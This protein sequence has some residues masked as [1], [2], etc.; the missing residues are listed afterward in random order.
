VTRK[1]EDETFSAYVFAGRLY[2]ELQPDL[3]VSITGLTTDTAAPAWRDLIPT[4]CIWLTVVFDTSG[5]VTS[6]TINSYG[7]SDDFDYTAAAWAGEDGYCEDDADPDYPRHQTS[8]IPL[9]YFFPDGDGAPVLSDVEGN[10]TKRQ[11]VTTDL[12]LMPVVI[13]SRPA[14]YPF[15]A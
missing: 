1:N 6:A 3:V 8:R 7:E 15:S 10:P 5:A 2:R 9:A 4:D 13:D 14:I 12:R 11:N